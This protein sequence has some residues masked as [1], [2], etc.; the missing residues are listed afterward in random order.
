[1]RLRLPGQLVRVGS[2]RKRTP[3][4][5]R[6]R[7]IHPEATRIL[8]DM[9]LTTACWTSLL[10]LTAASC[11]FV[12]A[13]EGWG[14]SHYLAHT[15]RGSGVRAEEDRQVTPFR[16]VELE[17]SATVRVTIGEAHAVHLSGDDNLLP[18]VTTRVQNGVLSLDVE[19][20][21]SFRCG[22]EV[23]ITTPSLERFTI[24][25]SGDVEIQGLAEDHVELAIDGSG[26]IR[27]QGTAGSLNGSIE[28]SGE[29]D[30]AELP[31]Q[32][33]ELSIEGSGS[34]LVQVAKELRYSIEGSG[35]IRYTGAPDLDG[36]IEG[37]GDIEKSR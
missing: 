23:Q 4:G 30:L 18:R 31:A 3:D 34:M 26:T 5:W 22:L 36:E 17:T 7:R 29:L 1:M 6:N 10:A 35:S 20:S 19:G 15:I 13:D 8:P 37:S 24:E 16:A 2:N 11:V 21:C 27:A 28:G 12:V 25:G 33:A 32:T 14:G 9:S